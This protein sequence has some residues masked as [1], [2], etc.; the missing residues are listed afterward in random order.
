MDTHLLLDKVAYQVFLDYH[1][2]MADFTS[3][4]PLEK[5]AQQL[6]SK[7]V[8]SAAAGYNLPSQLRSAISER[9]ANSPLIGQ[10]EEALKTVLTSPERSREAVAS[11]VQGGTILSPTQQQSIMAAQRAADVVP[12]ISINDLLQNQ[13]G[14]ISDLVNAGTGAYQ[15]Q[16]AADQG[17]AQLA[18]TQSDNAFTR[19][20]KQAELE[21]AQQKANQENQPSAIEKLLQ[22]ALLGSGQTN[23]SQTTTPNIP[24]VPG[25]I[26]EDDQ[27]GIQ[28]QAAQDG[29][30]VQVTPGLSFTPTQTEQPN[31]WQR[32][33]GGLNLGNILGGQ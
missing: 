32:L 2:T 4:E 19:L 25:T 8:T 17:K 9:F 6:E 29:S 18:R 33:F 1:K 5:T 28:Y 12:L 3:I 13:F 23:T 26:I 14:S 15:A 7:A 20:I 16:V 11:K 21:L 22:Q 10:R 24:G 27:T 30:W 31:W